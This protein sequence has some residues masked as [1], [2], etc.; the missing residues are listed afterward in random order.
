MKFSKHKSKRKAASIG[1]G[2]LSRRAWVP[3]G[4]FH[5][6]WSF[7]VKGEVFYVLWRKRGWTGGV[8]IK[9]SKMTVGGHTNPLVKNQKQKSWCGKGE[10]KRGRGRVASEGRAIRELAGRGKEKKVLGT[11]TKLSKKELQRLKEWAPDRCFLYDLHLE[12]RE[13]G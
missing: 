6:L 13:A 9:I 1:L 4:V 10:G 3:G 12:G 8:R 5:V 11:S 7:G 2:V